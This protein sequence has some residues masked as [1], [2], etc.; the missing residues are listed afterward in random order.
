MTGRKS[1]SKQFSDGSSYLLLVKLPGS[2]C[3]TRRGGIGTHSCKPDLVSIED[4]TS[5]AGP[6][7][8]NGI[9]A[10]MISR[11][12]QGCLAL[13]LRHALYRVPDIFNPLV[14]KAC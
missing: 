8:F 5:M 9:A 4:L 11:Q 7:F 13:I 12:H 10:A 2:F 14:G 1:K 6:F 3:F